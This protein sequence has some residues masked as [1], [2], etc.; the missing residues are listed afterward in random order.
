MPIYEYVCKACQHS[1]DALQKISDQPLII[2]PACQADGLT[3]CIS[4]PAFQLKGSGWYATDF[5]TKPN[6]TPT[7]DANTTS[8]STTA[9]TTEAATK[10][11]TS[12]ETTSC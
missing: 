11:T 3:K 5:K 4:A 12:G 2:C 1:F 8:P 10:K 9:P 7:A 6:S